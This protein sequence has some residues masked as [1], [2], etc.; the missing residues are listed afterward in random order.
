M[1]AVFPRV[2]RASL[3]GIAVCSFITGGALLWLGMNRETASTLTTFDLLSLLGLFVLPA[4][5][6]AL[7]VNDRRARR[8]GAPAPQRAAWAAPSRVRRHIPA[9]DAR[10]AYAPTPRRVGAPGRRAATPSG[11]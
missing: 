9:D 7:I 5:A 1:Q 2:R 6:I 3:A 4:G 8:A 10:A 11:R